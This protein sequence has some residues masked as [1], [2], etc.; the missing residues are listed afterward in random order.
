M[1]RA[2]LAAGFH[3]DLCGDQNAQRNQKTDRSKGGSGPIRC[4][5]L[6]PCGVPVF[7]SRVEICAAVQTGRPVAFRYD[8]TA[9]TAPVTIGPRAPPA[10][11]NP[12]TWYYG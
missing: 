4:A 12:A 2:L 1:F 3:S 8:W 7:L 5:V 10:P 11:A 9:A 6:P